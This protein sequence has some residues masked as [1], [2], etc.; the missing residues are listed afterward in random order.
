[1][2]LATLEK[3]TEIHPIDGADFIQM[4]RVLGYMT[5][6]KKGEFKVGDLCCW[7]NPDTTVARA[8]WNQFLW[9]KDDKDP[10]GKRIRIKACKFRGQISQ[11]L[12]V[13]LKDIGEIFEKDGIKYLKI[14]VNNIDEPISK[15]NITK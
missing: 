15:N 11:G 12:A 9:P 5:V 10:V 14:G 1:M 7:I 13:P 6:I 2:K 8:P 4:A 3:I